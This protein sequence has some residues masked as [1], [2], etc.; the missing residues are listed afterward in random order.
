[1]TPQKRFILGGLGALLP[2]IASLVNLVEIDMNTLTSGKIV[3]ATIKDCALFFL[4]GFLAYLHEDEIKPFKIVQIGIA[5]PALILALMSSSNIAELQKQLKQSKEESQKISHPEM[6][7]PKND[8]EHAKTTTFDFSII[9]SAHAETGEKLYLA[10]FFSDVVKGLKG[11]FYSDKP[12]RKAITSQADKNL[13]ITTATPTGQTSKDGDIYRFSISINPNSNAFSS[14]RKVQYDF[15][16]STFKNKHILTEDASNN[17][18]Y[19]YTGWGCL[20]S[21]G[22]TIT[23]IDGISK[24]Y[25]F[26]MCQ[27][28]GSEWSDE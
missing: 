27:S 11:D 26:D 2:I 20:T 1:M 12:T 14:I 15:E 25:D 22:V 7:P 21:V 10:G 13:F 5:S 3:G 8:K 28:L 19:S 4:G 6:L 23:S 9:K 16:H 18:L 24:N 17:F